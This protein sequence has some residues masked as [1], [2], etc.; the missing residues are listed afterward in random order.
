[1]KINKNKINATK[2]FQRNIGIA[3]KQYYHQALSDNAKRAWE[4]RRRKLST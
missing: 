2:Q 4:L 3:L 1:M